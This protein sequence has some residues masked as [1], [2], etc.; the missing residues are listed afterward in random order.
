MMVFETWGYKCYTECD[1][2]ALCELQSDRITPE[3]ETS[4]IQVR[5]NSVTSHYLFDSVNPTHPLKGSVLGCLQQGTLGT[6][7]RQIRLN[8]S[9]FTPS[10]LT[11]KVSDFRHVTIWNGRT[12]KNLNGWKDIMILI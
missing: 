6:C 10:G 2:Q 1:K 7:Y 4:Q 9:I 3:V 5:V 12:C 11:F 8:C